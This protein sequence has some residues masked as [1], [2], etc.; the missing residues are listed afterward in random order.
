MSWSTVYRGQ[1]VNVETNSANEANQQQVDV[2]I[3]D[4]ESAETDSPVD[5][6]DLEM[7]GEPLIIQVVNNSEDKFST[8]KSKRAEIKIYSGNGIDIETFAFGGDNRW[9]V[10][11]YY[12]SV[13]KF[14]GW[15]SLSDLQQDFQPDPNEILLTATDGLGFLEGEE[16]RDAD[17]E[18]YQNEHDIMTYISACLN[19]TRLSLP[20]W[21]IFNIRERFATPLI[22]DDSGDGHFFKHE[23]L[24]AKTF[25]EDILSA[26]NCNEALDMILRK[27]AYITQVDGH[28]LVVRIDE[29]QY[30]DSLYVFKFTSAG[31]FIEQETINPVKEIGVN[32]LLSWMNDDCLKS[33]ERPAKLVRL[34]FD[35]N[36]PEEIICNIDYTRGAESA[37]QWLSGYT[38]YDIECWTTSRNWGTNEVAANT[39]AH[40]ARK[41]NA[42]DV[43]E[44]RF[45]VIKMPASATNPQTYIKSSAV[46]ISQYDKF[47]WSFDYSAQQ[48][49]NSSDAFILGIAIT[50]L[51]GDDGSVWTLEDGITEG[52]PP[53]W[54]E[55]DEQLSIFRNEH[56]WDLRPSEQ[57]LTEWRSFTVDAPA[58]PVSGNLRFYLY[59]ANRVSSDA[60]NFHIRYSNIS[61]TMYPFINGTYRRF[62]GQQITITQPTNP[63]KYK[64]VVE[65]TVEISD[66]P[67]MAMKG[68]LLKSNGIG[69]YELTEG[70]YSAAV[71]PN[72]DFPDE[73]YIHPY[74]HLQAYDVWNQYYR[75]MRKFDGVVD[76]LG[77][78][79]D[80]LD[81]WQK[82]KLTD[83]NLSTNGKLFMVLHSEADLHLCETTIS[84]A[85]VHDENISK[86]Y[87]ANE[88]K[89][90]E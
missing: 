22:S 62:T 11:I 73:T 35:F 82:I 7:S 26:K 47:T 42:F 32:N 79:D 33:T 51:Y 67:R 90:I 74:Y 8:I 50:V 56:E 3:Y 13:V 75:V 72:G 40:I 53:S 2:Y 78:D 65:D 30:A 77:V 76:H 17:G 43:E 18:L 28:W 38:L 34:K 20:I 12:N 46:P 88:F 9:Y 85:E 39:T 36:Y 81:I 58:A 60:D 27:E 1:F 10:E 69:G 5:Y 84:L 59:A 15:L 68:C 45:I 44:E 19:K 6:I 24:N 86:E 25:E 52:D 29:L 66:A 83:P 70:F 89:Y 87:P 31:V 55:S 71:F 63:E 80:I 41:F 16:L 21:C 48:D 64:L 37:D 4:T 23:F 54:E 61:L 49:N 57:D 14:I